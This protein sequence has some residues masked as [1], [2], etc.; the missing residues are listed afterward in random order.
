MAPR[1]PAIVN[2]FM[3]R[4][5]NVQPSIVDQNPLNSSELPIRRRSLRLKRFRCPGTSKL[6][7]HDSLSSW[8][9]QQE[10]GLDLYGFG[11]WMGKQNL[12]LFKSNYIRISII[13]SLSKT[14][15]VPHFVLSFSLKSLFPTF[16]LMSYSLFP[17][18]RCLFIIVAVD[19]L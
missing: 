10:L 12:N 13:Y 8:Q 17:L 18:I 19:L 4:V 2:G 9:L 3:G 11:I 16:F 14:L 15:I 7:G 1:F 6:R 5:K